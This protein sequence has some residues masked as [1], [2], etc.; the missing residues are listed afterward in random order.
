MI[1]S[2]NQTVNLIA[3]PILKVRVAMPVVLRNPGPTSFW[4]IETSLRHSHHGRPHASKKDPTWDG[5]T[6]WNEKRKELEVSDSILA[7]S[8]PKHIRCTQKWLPMAV[9]LG[10]P[11]PQL[12][13]KLRAAG[14]VIG[15]PSCES[16]WILSPMTH[17]YTRGINMGHQWLS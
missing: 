12:Q 16:R 10:V 4:Q 1:I 6:G 8:W 3:G 7:T 2:R 11:G 5:E 9:T 17:K 13:P 14:P 15:T